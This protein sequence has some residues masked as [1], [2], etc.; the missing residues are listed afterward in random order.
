[1]LNVLLYKM[2]DAEIKMNYKKFMKYCKDPGILDNRNTIPEE[3][4]HYQQWCITYGSN[5]RPIGEFY[6]D[7]IKSFQPSSVIDPST[8]MTWERAQTLS[9]FPNI[10]FVLT[11]KDPYCVIDLDTPE[12]LSQQRLHYNIIEHFNKLTYVERSRSRTGFHIWMK[13]R[14][15]FAGR[16][17]N[18]H[19]IEIYSRERFM[20]CTDDGND[21]PIKDCS[22][23]LGILV[24]KLDIQRDSA[25]VDEFNEEQEMADKIII[26]RIMIAYKNNERKKEW[27]NELCAGKWKDKYP[28]QS[29]ADYFLLTMLCCYSPNNDQVKRIFRFTGLGKRAKATRNDRY[30]D[31]SI[32][33]I[34]SLIGNGKFS[35]TIKI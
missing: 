5:K 34:R 33:K 13:V 15:S 29:E 23:Q 6:A 1:M 31:A 20:I 4:K 8:W 18:K 3:L 22:A 35:G 25:P 9:Y 26:D 14:S 12:T 24:R 19:R 11:R 2:T 27:F 28:S 16:R 17:S 32:R 30:L 10:G 21:R 7:G